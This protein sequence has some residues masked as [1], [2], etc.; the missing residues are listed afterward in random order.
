MTPPRVLI[1]DDDPA[2]LEA[3]PETIHL[4]MPGTIVETAGAAGPALERIAAVDYDAILSDIKMPG[5]DGLVLLGD[6][7]AARPDTPVLLITGHGEH[8]LAIRSLRSGA[9]D[10]I[11]KPIDREYLI[12]S[13]GRA[14]QVRQLRRQIAEQQQALTRHAGYLETTVQERTSEL[15]RT[16]EQLRALT[17]VATAIHGARGVDQVLR[18]VVNAACRVSGA[19]LAVA[20]FYRGADQSAAPADPT[21]WAIAMAPDRANREIATADLARTVAAVCAAD[22]SPA[23]LPGEIFAPLAPLAADGDG[24]SPSF[25]AL[26]VRSREGHPLGALILAEPAGRVFAPAV[27]V[28][29]EALALQVA[30]ALENTRLYER[31][32][33]TAETLQRS[34]MPERLPEIPG[35]GI[36]ARYLPGNHESVGGDW[37]DVLTLPNGHVGLVIGDVAGRGVW[38]AAVMG[39]LRN[40]LRAYALEGN[41]P[42]VIAQRLAGL[43]DERTMATLVYLIIEPDTGHVR[44]LN[45][46]HLPPLVLGP[47]GVTALEGGSAPPLGVRGIAYREETATLPARSTLLVYTDG[48][49]DERGQSLDEG[50]A[51]LT[52]ALARCADVPVD[53]LLDGVLAAVQNGRTAEDDTALVALRLVPLNPARLDIRLPAVPSS[54]AQMRQ[55]V[56]RWLRTADLDEEQGYEILT[57]VNEACA[58]SIEHAYGLRDGL[59]ECELTL[60]DGVLTAVVRDI[61]RWRSARGEHRGNGLK[62]MEALMGEVEVIAAHAG[63]AVRMRKRVVQPAGVPV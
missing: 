51:R 13:L 37:Y 59:F 29:I 24:A 5:K 3:L 53:D 46:G 39:Q 61:G 27:R 62:L 16:I 32:R 8:D 42:A 52:A 60:H 36:A 31:T 15:R 33:G 44:Y 11:Q 19:G 14:V 17:D 22:R 47:D 34:L 38:A 43:V 35:L 4:R 9:Y 23:H 41:P 54:L 26:P 45:L 58:N 12:A 48:L 1:I 57:A 56:R 49:L 40:A 63:T 30:V 50:L 21:R 28:Q 20:G 25:L 55:T 18:A 7:R 10:Y 6:V 2:L